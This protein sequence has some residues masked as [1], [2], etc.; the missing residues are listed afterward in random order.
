VVRPLIP[1]D[2]TEKLTQMV[3]EGQAQFVEQPSPNRSIYSLMVDD[4]L[5]TL[6]YSHVS[7]EVV[8][9]SVDEGV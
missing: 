4:R 2:R 3:H 6:I 1:L 7:R 8:A 9:F 5:L